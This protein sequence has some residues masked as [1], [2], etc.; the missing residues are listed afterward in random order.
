MTSKRNEEDFDNDLPQ[1][2]DLEEF[3]DDAESDTIPCPVCGEDI[4]EDAERCPNCEN[5]VVPEEEPDTQGSWALLAVVALGV[6]IILLLL[7]SSC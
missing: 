7:R 1:D 5:Y 3:G 6:V 4:Y 2:I